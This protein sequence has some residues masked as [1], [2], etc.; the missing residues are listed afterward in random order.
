ML[1]INYSAAMLLW[2]VVA[3]LPLGVTAAYMSATSRDL[4]VVQRLAVSAHGVALSALGFA[5]L[6]V[7]TEGTPQQSTWD[8]FGPACSLP[9]VLISYSLLKF[10]GRRWVH[11]LQLVNVA[12]LLAFLVFGRMAVTGAWL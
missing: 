3:S 1:L 2:V 5:A 6:L 10:A 9:L 12:W 7:S 8:I 4:S 11:A